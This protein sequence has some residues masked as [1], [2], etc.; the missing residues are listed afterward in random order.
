[1]AQS[2]SPKRERKLEA[3][4]SEL[5]R[6]GRYEG[7]QGE[8]GTGTVA[9]QRG[10]KG[11]IPAARTKDPAHDPVVT[12][13]MEVCL[14]APYNEI[15]QL[16]GDWND[17]KPIDM[18][19]GGDGWWRANI[20][21][22]DGEHQY[23]FRVKSRSYFSFDEMVDIFDP[24]ALS[25]TG[26]KDQKGIMV[27]KNGQREW[28]DYQWQH[29]HI[30]LP[31]NGELLIYE[32]HV[33]DFAGTG[34]SG[35]FKDVIDKLDYIEDLGINCVELMPVKEFPGKGWGYSLRSLFAVEN[36]YGRPEDLC[37]LVDECHARGIRVVI[38]GVYNHAEK[39]APLTKIDFEY[40]FYK[41]NP[42]PPEMHWGPKFNYAQYDEKL[43]IFPARK[44]VIDSILFWVEKFHID[45]VRFDATRA[46][47]NFDIM[48][49]M[50]DAAYSKINGLKHFLTVAEHVPEDPAIAGRDRGAPMDAAWHEGL[51]NE[52][53]QILTFQRNPVNIDDLF[54]KL[55]P[56][57]NGYGR[58][59]RMVNFIVSHDQS[60]IMSLLGDKGK[61]FD[62]VAFRRAKLGI[63]LILT[64]PGLPMLW[65]GTEFGFAAEK[66][67]E[68]RPLDWDLLKN[69]ANR[70]LFNYVQG[71]LKL[72]RKTPALQGET[73]EIVMQDNERQIF[74]YKRWNGE[75]NVV[76]VAI[77][78]KDEHNGEFVI[79]GPSLEDGTWHEYTHNYDVEVK[80]GKLTDSLAESEVKVYIKK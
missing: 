43:G 79:Q 60:R 1:M 67:L 12:G 18:Q 23:K 37:R 42:D 57:T 20:V 64:C 22:P 3:I 2:V 70:D 25:V 72:R 16:L 76:I 56:A 11:A 48:K 73:L 77:N 17:F 75:G 24:Y 59:D 63:G 40:W 9:T 65:M 58:P 61:V 8:M 38:D 51:A 53:Q 52:L 45:G 47:G 55:G 13:T 80:H 7:S 54:T 30:V 19:K 46:I 34:K 32:L 49:E 29:D 4:E 27:V 5:K 36:S 44:Y 31:A 68:P 62:H 50:T 15:V 6:E 71:L 14:F 41:E 69:D 74:A 26:E 21:I 78:L 33:Q 10:E 28:V 35:T 39:E 66:S